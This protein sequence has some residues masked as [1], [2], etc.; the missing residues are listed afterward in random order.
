MC[1]INTHCVCVYNYAWISLKSCT[2]R[3]ALTNE[4]SKLV[5]CGILIMYTPTSNMHLL[6]WWQYLRIYSEITDWS[7][8][9][10]RK[11]RQAGGSRVTTIIYLSIVTWGVKVFCIAWVFRFI[12]SV[13]IAI[14]DDIR[15]KVSLPS[16]FP[17]LN[18]LQIRI[19]LS[20]DPETSLLPSLDQEIDHT[21]DVWPSKVFIFSQSPSSSSNNFIELS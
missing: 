1:Y 19:V 15:R 13:Q 7:D 6:Q 3:E 5:D 20:S 17:G 16:I 14:Q 4:H 21:V 12:S 18:F 11:Q 10:D 8:A 2:Y 9:N